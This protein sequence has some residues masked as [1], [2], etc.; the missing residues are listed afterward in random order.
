MGADSQR[1]VATSEEVAERCGVGWEAMAAGAIG[2]GSSAAEAHVGDGG[3]PVASRLADKAEFLALTKA[4][5]E[6]G[7]GPFPAPL[8]PQTT[9]EDPRENSET[10]GRPGAAA[11]LFPRDAPPTDMAQRRAPPPT[12]P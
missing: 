5:G 1:R 10:N 11:P 12:R 3:L 2:L 7:R 4:M 8:G 9:T 6:A